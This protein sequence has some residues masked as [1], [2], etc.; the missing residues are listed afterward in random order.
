LVDFAIRVAA[1]HHA[2]EDAGILHFV[3][4]NFPAEITAPL[5]QR[6]FLGVPAAPYGPLLLLNI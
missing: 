5:G 2:L 6:W 1:I 4:W 3:L